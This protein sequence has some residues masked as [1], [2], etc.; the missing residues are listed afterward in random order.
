MKIK[1]DI[2]FKKNNN[3]NCNNNSFIDRS[4]NE[5]IEYI[6]WS[7]GHIFKNSLWMSRSRYLEKVSKIIGDGK[8]V[9]RDGR[10]NIYNTNSFISRK[11]NIIQSKTYK[12][13][14]E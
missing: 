10:T 13:L 1:L 8:C 3:E 4:R 12:H 5:K 7:E 14:G 6:N 11:Y 2:F 9:Y